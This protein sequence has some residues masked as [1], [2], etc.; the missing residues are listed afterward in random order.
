VDDSA[1]KRWDDYTVARD[2][3]LKRTHDRRVPWI[4]VRSD[5][6]KS[7]RINIIRDLTQRIECP[8]KSKHLTAPDRR[9]LFSYSPARLKRLAR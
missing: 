2:A 1:F 9:R 7:A 3:M 5:D 6:K 4:L 8:D